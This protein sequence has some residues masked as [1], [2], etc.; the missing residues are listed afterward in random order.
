MTEMWCVVP[1]L[2]DVPPEQLDPRWTEHPVNGCT[3]ATLLNWKS[4]YP[5][6]NPWP[7]TKWRP[8]SE[9]PEWVLER[10]P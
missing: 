7:G 5:S 6:W 1:D 2:N 8:M 3:F 9:A 10:K 4:E